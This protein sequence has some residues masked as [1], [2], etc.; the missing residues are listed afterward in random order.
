MLSAFENMPLGVGFSKR[1]YTVA[2]ASSESP[3]STAPSPL[4]SGSPPMSPAPRQPIEALLSALH[5][6]GE[7]FPD[8]TLAQLEVFL[9]LITISG[10]AEK[11]VRQEDL[12]FKLKRP[13][14]TIAKQLNKFVEAGILAKNISSE[15]EREKTY[16][17]T[18]DGK[19]LM[20][21]VET[22]LKG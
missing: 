17:L 7:L 11:D 21:R 15:S 22:L 19:R 18:R 8:P 1:R 16:S 12:G 13:Q 20:D 4:L 2:N 10:E 6:F 9:T 14:G 5:E 3:S